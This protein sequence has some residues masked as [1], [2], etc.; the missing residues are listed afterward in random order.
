M[1]WGKGRT[2]QDVQ[3]FI[4]KKNLL[5]HKLLQDLQRL[6]IVK[7]ADI[8]CAAYY[9]LRRFIG[10]DPNWRVF[11]RKHVRLTGHYVDLLI[12]KKYRPVIAIELKWNRE[13]IGRKDRRS[14]DGAIIDLHVQKA[15]WLSLIL[16]EKVRKT[17]KFRK[18]SI[19]KNALFILIG[20]LGLKGKKLKDYEHRRK[21]FKSKMGIGKGHK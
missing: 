16:R 15:Y 10:Q 12:F 6:K 4:R 14:L 2:L 21:R 8:E 11:A 3:N 1:P 7:E 19:E 5:R 13:N 20:K 9:Y 17:K 18:S